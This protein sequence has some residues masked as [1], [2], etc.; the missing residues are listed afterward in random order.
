MFM[1]E[2]RFFQNFVA[3]QIH[4]ISRESA[5]NIL[6]INVLYDPTNPKVMSIK[7]ISR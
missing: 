4:K 6:D 5:L 2:N 3:K 7:S 1:K